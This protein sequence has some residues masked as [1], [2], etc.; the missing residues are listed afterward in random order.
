MRTSALSKPAGFNNHHIAGLDSLRFFCAIWVA[1]HHGARPHLVLWLGLSPV[2]EDWNAITYDGVAAVILFFVISGLCV[3]YPHARSLSCNLPAFYAQ[4]FV[5]VGTPLL[6]VVAFELGAQSLGVSHVAGDIS[7]ALRTVIWSLWCEL[8]YYALYP[9]FLIGF[10]RIGLIPIIAASFVAA[11]VAIFDHWNLLTYWQYPK[12]LAWITALPAWLMGCAL[13]QAIVA[14]R[15][16]VLPGSVWTWRIGA[17]LLSIPPKALVYPDVSPVLI[18]NPATLGPYAVFA[19]FWVSKEVHFY[20]SHRPPATLEWGGRW[21]YSIYLVHNVVIVFFTHHFLHPYA[22]VL[23]PME[24]AAVLIMSY[25]FYR[26]VE[27]PSHRLARTLGRSFARHEN[28]IEL[29]G[30]RHSGRGVDL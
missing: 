25:V 9:A 6:I 30:V 29:V 16:P 18:G 14:G 17:I 21:S 3:H 13:A 23:W 5:R 4:R 24:I 7:S 1:L 20:Q 26:L 2:F 15:L 8:I 10:Q 28:S 27:Y 11:Y 22:F 12:T 19:F